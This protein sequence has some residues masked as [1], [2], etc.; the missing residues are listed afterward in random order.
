MLTQAKRKQRLAAHPGAPQGLTGAGPSRWHSPPPPQL[1]GQIQTGPGKGSGR[2]VTVG[3]ASVPAPGGPLGRGAG[4][5]A[6]L[7][8]GH[9]WR[10]SRGRRER[11]VA[12]SFPGEGWHRGLGQGGAVTLERTRPGRWSRTCSRVAAMSISF[13]PGDRVHRAA[14]GVF[15]EG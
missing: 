1:S 6:W 3:L 11:Q 9:S 15:R 5:V 12:A 8:E 10:R 7:G 4:K 13:T 2:T 14:Q